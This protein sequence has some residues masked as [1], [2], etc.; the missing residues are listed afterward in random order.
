MSEAFE[1]IDLGNRVMVDGRSKTILSRGHKISA[2]RSGIEVWR[3]TL[4][5]SVPVDYLIRFEG[6]SAPKWFLY[7]PPVREEVVA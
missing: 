5:N 4:L 7:R 6:G 2:D 3:V 1:A